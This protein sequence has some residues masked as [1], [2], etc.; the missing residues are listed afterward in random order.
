MLQKKRGQIARAAPL[1]ISTIPQ[2]RKHLKRNRDRDTGWNW[3]PESGHSFAG[4]YPSVIGVAITA[5]V[6]RKTVCLCSKLVNRD[7]RP[8]SFGSNAPTFVA[9]NADNASIILKNQF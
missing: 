8:R 4:C 2:L 5:G 7:Q 6:V 1:L 9:S 3:F